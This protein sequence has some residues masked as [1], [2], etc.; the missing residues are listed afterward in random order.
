MKFLLCLL[1][2][3]PLAY[4]A[5]IDERF[6]LDTFGLDSNSLAQSLIGLLGSDATEAQCES[7]CQSQ[8]GSVSFLCGPAC[9]EV[10]ALI[11]G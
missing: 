6:I 8:F 3:L 9:K 10:Q 7:L 5:S 1:V 11:N 4:C 2:L